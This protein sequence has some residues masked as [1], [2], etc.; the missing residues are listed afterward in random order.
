MLTITH[1][2]LRF[3]ETPLF[4]PLSLEIAAGEIALLMAPSG[5]GKSTLLSWICGMPDPALIASGTIHLN[6]QSLDHLPPEKRGI[7]IMFQDPL[8]FPHLSVAGNL[9]FGMKPG[10]TARSRR[11]IIDEQLDR[12][13]LGGLGDRDPLTLSGGQ[14]AR[15][16]LMRSLMAEPQALLL[17]EPFS[18]LDDD[19]RATFSDLVRAEISLR[20]LPVLIVSHDPRDRAQAET[21][22]I[23][24]EPFSSVTAEDQPSISI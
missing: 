19:T 6:G 2:N 1:A 17:D 3:G 23:H 16:A 24:L 14:K 15:L 5:A 11:A 21:A 8:M 18:G 7:G 10:G 12:I 13:G 20:Q 9:A 22:P 4:Q